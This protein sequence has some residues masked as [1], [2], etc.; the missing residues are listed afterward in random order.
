MELY[1]PAT[2]PIQL[3]TF[4]RAATHTRQADAFHVETICSGFQRQRN[5]IVSKNQHYL[6]VFALTREFSL[7]QSD[8]VPT[9]SILSK[10]M[11]GS[12]GNNLTGLLYFARS[13]ELPGLM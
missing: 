10:L 1:L 5:N 8:L 13:I 11:V 7:R 2:Q 4:K 3:A 12:T 9:M 6:F